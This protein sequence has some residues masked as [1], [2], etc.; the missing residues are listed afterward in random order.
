M[1]HPPHRGYIGK[2]A[3]FQ[4]IVPADYNDS[5]LDGG[6]VGLTHTGLHGVCGDP[7][8][9]I[10]DHETG[11]KYGTFPT[12]RAKAIGACYAPGS[13]IDVGIQLTTNHDGYFEFSL[14][15]LDGPYDVESEP[16]F[17][18]LAQ[19][20]GT[21]RWQV[22]HGTTDLFRL[23]Y[24]L[25]PHVTCDGEAHCVVRWWYVGANDPHGAIHDQNQVWNCADV[26][27]SNA[28]WRVVRH[29]WPHGTT[30]CWLWVV[31]P[32]R[33]RFVLRGRNPVV[34]PSQIGMF[35]HHHLALSASSRG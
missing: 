21:T 10:R 11:G 1:I 30:S 16:C 22:P 7:Y 19:P 18:S 34:R 4:G 5:D 6:G 17:Q 12:H 26:Y 27:I 20:N 33:D 3:P 35:N 8:Y 32:D 25:P 28:C 15:K 9:G 31:C 2:L 23:Q 13:T 29:H 14:C 24:V